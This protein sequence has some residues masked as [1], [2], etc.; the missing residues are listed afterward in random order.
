MRAIA[1]AAVVLYHAGAAGFRFMAGWAGGGG[2]AED[3]EVAP[4]PFGGREDSGIAG[5]PAG[6]GV[7]APR[8]GGAGGPT[9][10]DDAGGWAVPVAFDG[11]LACGALS[12]AEGAEASGITGV[13]ASSSAGL[14]DAGDG[15]SRSI[16]D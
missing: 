8:A 10:G 6:A 14:S 7:L 9:S 16:V 11:S 4:D 5:G 15:S 1:V 13:C 3:F 12:V 2:K